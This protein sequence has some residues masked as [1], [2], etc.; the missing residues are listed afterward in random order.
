MPQ[1]QAETEEVK[2]RSDIERA[3]Q[4]NALWKRA[5]LR[6]LR[7][8]AVHVERFME[9]RLVG[10]AAEIETLSRW[11]RWAAHAALCNVRAAH[12]GLRARELRRR[13]AAAELAKGGHVDA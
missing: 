9:D 1:N 4:W 10:E 5:E 7:R 8:L 11:Y 2:P 13:H 3:L 6:N 12:A